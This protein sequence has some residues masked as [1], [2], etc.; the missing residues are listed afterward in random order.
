[1]RIRLTCLFAVVACLAA[2]ATLQ[3]DWVGVA[4]TGTIDEGDLNKVVLNN[5]GSAAIRSNISASAKLRLQLA[6]TPTLRAPNSRPVGDEL[7]PLRFVMRVRDNGPSA[8]VIATLKRV[9]LGYFI[10]GP[11]RTDIAATIDSDLHP[12]SDG[13]VTIEAQHYSSCC[14]IRNPQL[15]FL[16]REGMDFFDA[17]WFVEIQLI[18]N[19]L[20]GNPGVMSV[21]VIRDEP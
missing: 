8:R 3:A 15:G 18:K 4:A 20:D 11:P 13:W 21:A 2:V 16:A 6:E 10:E 19:T 12:A 9:T 7:G 1:M 17:G 5:D 14:W